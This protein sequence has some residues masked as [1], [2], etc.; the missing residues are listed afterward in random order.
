[1]PAKSHVAP[2]DVKGETTRGAIVPAE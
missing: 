1:M 2:T